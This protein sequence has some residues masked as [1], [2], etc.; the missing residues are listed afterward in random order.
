MTPP[1]LERPRTSA[2]A[3]TSL[4]TGL[5]LCIPLVTQVA[6]IVSGILGFRATAKPHV[7]GRGFAIAGLVLGVVGLLGWAGVGF[8]GYSAFEASGPVRET[9]RTWIEDVAAGDTDAAIASSVPALQRA[10]VAAMTPYLMEHGGMLQSVSF[11]RFNVRT[12]N[13]QTSWTLGGTADFDGE[14]AAFEI[15]LVSAGDSY[16][17]RNF[18]INGTTR[19]WPALDPQG[20]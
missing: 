19:D 16:L 17:V 20:P 6:A 14:D 10:D 11:S 2:A 18:N 5:L 9:A 4:V 13:G 15:V 12:L 1:P 7:S 8:A 3:I